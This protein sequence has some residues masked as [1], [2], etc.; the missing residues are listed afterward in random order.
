MNTSLVLLV[1]V[2]GDGEAVADVEDPLGRP[3]AEEEPHDPFG[4]PHLAHPVEV[5]DHGQEDQRVHDH[6][7]DGGPG[8]VGR[9]RRHG[10]GLRGL[11]G[12]GH[13]AHKSDWLSKDLFRDLQFRL[14][15]SGM[16]W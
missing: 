1:L 4:V 14:Y 12:G 3:R 7:V 5:V 11:D 15:F 16:I 9:D 2:E 8:S 13:L 10:G 6:F